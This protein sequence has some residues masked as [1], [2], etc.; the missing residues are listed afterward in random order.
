MYAKKKQCSTML[1]LAHRNIKI[2]NLLAIQ[3]GKAN[4]NSRRSA[5]EQFLRFERYTGNDLGKQQRSLHTCTNLA[6]SSYQN[7]HQN[8][9]NQKPTKNFTHPYPL[10]KILNCSLDHSHEMSSATLILECP[11]RTMILALGKYCSW[12]SVLWYIN[13][14]SGQYGRYKD[15]RY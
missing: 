6:A 11:L 8:N 12:A 2:R 15:G 7:C 3:N 14:R 5:S 1:T 10:L 4:L 13:G 9:E